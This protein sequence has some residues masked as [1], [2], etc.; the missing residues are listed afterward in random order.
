MADTQYLFQ[1]RGHGTAWIFR[2]KTPA[3][4][5]G[6][7]NPRL[8]KPYKREIREGLDSTRSLAEARKLKV[9]TMRGFGWTG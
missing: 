1:P 9:Q 5:V 4:L 2:M 7:L 3:K 8:G 6:K